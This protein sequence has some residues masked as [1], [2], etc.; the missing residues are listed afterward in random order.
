MRQAGRLEAGKAGR[1]A[2]MAGR[3]T[4]RQAGR[5]RTERQRGRKADRQAGR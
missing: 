2:E 4:N 3:L 1:Q 5:K